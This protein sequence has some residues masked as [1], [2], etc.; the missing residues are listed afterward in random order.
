MNIVCRICRSWI[1]RQRIES[2][3]SQL[4]RVAFAW[5]HDAVLARRLADVAGHTAARDISLFR[6]GSRLR[7]TL[8][9]ALLDGFRAYQRDYHEVLS[10]APGEKMSAARRPMVRR[11]RQALRQLDELQRLIVALVDLGGCSYAEASQVLGIPRPELVA[12]LCH[13]RVHLKMQL[14]DAARPGAAATQ[15]QGWYAK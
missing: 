1:L 2:Q 3:R 12:Q 7:V 8:F 10:F 14:F 4:E 6:D 9:R 13:A 11:V 15:L 5:G